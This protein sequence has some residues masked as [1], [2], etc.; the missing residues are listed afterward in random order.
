MLKFFSLF[1]VFLI[2]GGSIQAGTLNSSASLHGPRVISPFGATESFRLEPHNATDYGVPI[3][4]PVLAPADGQ[5]VY[6]RGPNDDTGNPVPVGK[7]FLI[8][9]EQGYRTFYAHLEKILVTPG[10]VVKRGEVIALSG[11]TGTSPDGKWKTIYPHLHFRLE[12]AKAEPI[13]PYPN[14]WHGGKGKPLAFDPDVV[15]LDRPFA[16]THPVAYGEYF[17]TARERAGAMRQ[18]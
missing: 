4:T 5:V 16:L 1:T 6:V 17:E 15:Y 13:D 10:Q 8:Q 3:G 12:N 14:Y 18:E 2:V 11:N 7:H 9:H